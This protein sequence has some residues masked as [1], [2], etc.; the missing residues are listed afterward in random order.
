M[1]TQNV[2]L[3]S[4]AQ[5]RGARGLLGMTQPALAAAAE[6]GLST[7]VDFERSRRSVS[8]EAV[9]KIREALERA[10]IEFIREN[11]GGL[12]VRLRKGSQKKR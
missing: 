11:G 9:Q 5:C 10:G 2:D 6:L 8:N 7:I 1:S 4:P 12:G 3:I